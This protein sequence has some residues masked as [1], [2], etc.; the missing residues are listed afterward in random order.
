MKITSTILI[1]IQCTLVLPRE[2]QKENL[3]ML[4]SMD[5]IINLMSTEDNKATESANKTLSTNNRKTGNET[6]A[7]PTVEKGSNKTLLPMYP[8]KTSANEDL[9]CTC[10]AGSCSIHPDNIK[11]T[12]PRTLL[13]EEFDN[14]LDNH[15]VEQ[16]DPFTNHNNGE[17]QTEGKEV[18]V[19]PMS[20][21]EHLFVAHT[22]AA[23]KIVVFANEVN[24]PLNQEYENVVKSGPKQQQGWKILLRK[25][26]TT[27]S[28]LTVKTITILLFY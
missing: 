11:L 10:E 4:E 2:I 18:I 24:L 6:A 1:R 3:G 17:Q 5:A 23:K 22:E 12:E 27:L 25:A 21:D 26:W 16:E 15:R 28:L 7:D 8:Y 20:V 13:Q 9:I 14:I 19:K